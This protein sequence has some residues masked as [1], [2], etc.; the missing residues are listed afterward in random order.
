MYRINLQE[1]DIQEE[2]GVEGKENIIID[3]KLIVVMRSWI[4]LFQERVYWRSLVNAALKSL[5]TLS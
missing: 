5:D 2:L 1:R 3:H 4:D